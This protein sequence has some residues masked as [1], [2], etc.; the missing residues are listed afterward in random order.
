MVRVQ[1]LRFGFR[2]AA[3]ADDSQAL[4]FAGVEI[5]NASG[6][7]H[8]LRRGELFLQRAQQKLSFARVGA[9]AFG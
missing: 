2:L 4:A 8:L 1:S 7:K 3:I 6:G 5:F 9:D